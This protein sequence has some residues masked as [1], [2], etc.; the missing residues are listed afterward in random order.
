MHAIAHIA[1]IK[2]YERALLL[3]VR[4]QRSLPIA[5]KSRFVGNVTSSVGALA[6]EFR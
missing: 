5:H 3:K 4:L 1:A 2:K 6:L